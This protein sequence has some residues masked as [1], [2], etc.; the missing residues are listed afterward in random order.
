MYVGMYVYAYTYM[1]IYIYVFVM[2]WRYYKNYD[3]LYP[4]GYTPA[5]EYFAS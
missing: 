5:I 1:Y 4:W 2:C 3:I